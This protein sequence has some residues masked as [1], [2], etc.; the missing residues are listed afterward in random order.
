MYVIFGSK[1]LKT[2][3]ETKRNTLEMKMWAVEQALSISGKLVTD[4]EGNR[5][6]PSH[7]EILKLAIDIYNFL[8]EE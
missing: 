5:Y 7:V 8:K 2:M 1:L 3:E 4:D 6:P